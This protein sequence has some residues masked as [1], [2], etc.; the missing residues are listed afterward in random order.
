MKEGH[1]DSMSKLGV[2]ASKAGE[3]FIITTEAFENLKN[4]SIKYDNGSRYHK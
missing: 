4:N 2:S 3:A 1:M